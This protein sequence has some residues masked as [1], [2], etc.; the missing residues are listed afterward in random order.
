MS[1]ATNPLPTPASMKGKKIGVQDVNSNIWKAFLKVN[2]I[3]ESDLTTV[4]VGFTTEELVA[5]HVDGWFSFITNEP[6]ELAANG[7]KTVTFLLSDNGL[8]LASQHYI[9]N[10]DALKSNRDKIK[11]GLIAEIK[12]WRD[13]L[14][15]PAQGAA[16]AANTYGVDLKLDVTEQTAESA[17]QN[18]LILNDDTKANGIFTITDS[19][20]DQT[21]SSLAN[22]GTTITKEKL[23]DLS[24]IKEIY[25]ENPDLKKSPV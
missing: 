18:L 21:I 8:P 4:S 11:A 22:S 2:N 5:G 13:S 19:L 20:V 23:Y 14:K 1:L 25:S 15:D 3:A 6:V 7:T 9:V 17:A 24:L 16:L 10:T 12:G